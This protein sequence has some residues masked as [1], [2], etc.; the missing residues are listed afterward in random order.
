MEHLKVFDTVADF[1]AAKEQLESPYVALTEDNE[2]VQ[3]EKSEEPQPTYEY[4]DL[5]LPSGLKWATMNVGATSETEG[6][7]RFQ[8]GDTVGYADTDTSHSTW[9]TQPF[10]N[11]SSSFDSD[12]FESHKSVWLNGDTL[13][14][15]Y[16]AAHV[17]MGGNWRMPTNEEFEE[18]LENTNVSWITLNGVNGFEFRS[19][20][21]GD[22]YIFIPTLYA[23]F[24]GRP[25]PNTMAYVWTST[26]NIGSPNYAYEL[27]INTNIQHVAASYLYNSYHIRGVLDA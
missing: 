18:L 14:P 3:Y 27:V 12:Y 24:S 17:H 11:G 1:E 8:W 25:I 20:T 6:G 23:M 13:K 16:D 5:G 4:V 10:N 26:L 7:L 2:K 19:K 22:N 15:E 9:S 21:N